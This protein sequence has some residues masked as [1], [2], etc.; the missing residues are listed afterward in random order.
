M[1]VSLERKMSSGLYPPNVVTL[2][3]NHTGT[4]TPA[5]ESPLSSEPASP[6]L[7][8]DD[9]EPEVEKTISKPASAK[10][11]ERKPINVPTKS[12]EV[13]FDEGGA[14]DDEKKMDEGDELMGKSRPRRKTN[15][16]LDPPDPDE[17]GSQPP[18]LSL[19]KTGGPSRPSV[20]QRR[21]KTTGDVDGT[22]SSYR[23]GESYLTLTNRSVLS[24]AVSTRN[25]KS[26]SNSDVEQHLNFAALKRDILSIHQDE[27]PAPGGRS[28][29]NS[30]EKGTATPGQDLRLGSRMD[31]ERAWQTDE[32]MKVQTRQPR[33]SAVT[34]SPGGA[35]V[36]S[37]GRRYFISNSRPSAGSGTSPLKSRSKSTTM[38]SPDGLVESGH[39]QPTLSKYDQVKS[40]MINEFEEVV[41]AEEEGQG[42][43]EKSQ[44]RRD[45][46]DNRDSMVYYRK[47]LQ[48][49]SGET[50]GSPSAS[51]GTAAT[52]DHPD[53]ERLSESTHVTD[54][55]SRAQSEGPDDE[56]RYLKEGDSPPRD[57]KGDFS[58]PISPLHPHGSLAVQDAVPDADS[59]SEDVADALDALSQ[60]SFQETLT[61]TLSD[62]VGLA[63]SG[64]ALV[65]DYVFRENPK[66][67]ET[68]SR[69][70]ISGRPASE[71]NMRSVEN[72]SALRF[73]STSTDWEGYAS[74]KNAT[75]A[76]LNNHTSDD[77]KIGIGR[78]SDRGESNKREP[79]YRQMTPNKDMQTSEK[80][81]GWLQEELKRRSTIKKEI[82]DSILAR[83]KVEA[84][85]DEI[86]EAPLAKQDVAEG[87][88]P[89]EQ[90]AEEL[91]RALNALPTQVD[92]SMDTLERGDGSQSTE[93][94][95]VA[96]ITEK[97]SAS[98]SHGQKN[99]L[100]AS[101]HRLDLHSRAGDEGADM[102]IPLPRRLDF[103]WSE[104]LKQ[105][106]LYSGQKLGS[107]GVSMHTRNSRSTRG[108]DD[109]IQVGNSGHSSGSHGR[110]IDGRLSAVPATDVSAGIRTRRTRSSLSGEGSAVEGAS[111]VDES[112]DVGLKEEMMRFANDTRAALR[113]SA[114]PMPK[115]ADAPLLSSPFRSIAIASSISSAAP[116]EMHSIEVD[117]SFKEP[118][119]RY[120]FEA[121]TDD[122]SLSIK[123]SAS[124]V[125]EILSSEE[126]GSEGDLSDIHS[127][128]PALVKSMDSV[129]GIAKGDITLS[130]LNENTGRI[131]T[132]KKA[133]WAN[134]VHGAIW[135][136]RRMRRT[137]GGFPSHKTQGSPG[138]RGRSSLPVEVDKARVAG[139]F[140]SVS[141]TQDAALTHLAHDE[142]DEALEL[143]EDII[144]A[145]YHYFERALKARE[146]RPGRIPAKDA[147]DFQAYIGVALHNLGILN[148]LN[149]EYKQAFSFF[150]RAIE[151]KKACL[152]EGHPDHVV[153]NF[154][155]G[156]KWKG[157]GKR[158]AEPSL[159]PTFPL[160]F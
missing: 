126:A 26:G 158:L 86:N 14:P 140:K 96:A 48:I 137:M 42:H 58:T 147:D 53:D 112:L 68:L 125:L 38:I 148:L 145:Y 36:G 115:D 102:G 15:L 73:T 120:P 82:N 66:P 11:P 3:P 61:S 41:A 138:M 117:A 71:M 10:V 109:R 7:D 9:E 2:S 39:S 93:D 99:A 45:V 34:P 52:N 28:L 20:I 54:N 50:S 88:G 49:S 135:R 89:N 107:A 44:Y 146:K 63:A 24:K 150:S 131:D 143:F 123:S 153:S 47:Y 67:L 57:V 130:L 132:S 84:D 72:T 59:V 114:V 98:S 74:K 12:T 95:E 92:D 154:Y 118:R 124:R 65:T 119:T 104:P 90:F 60:L 17:D 30:P 78:G 127:T 155:W 69:P 159:I 83:N 77:G 16:R 116:D 108:S 149:G 134:R 40:Q 46:N 157:L 100:R 76:E 62:A 87:G 94:E 51:E 144:F 32:A 106:S 122:P 75:T 23:R 25:V 5:P 1:F 80:S 18:S 129:Y 111:R 151:N 35:L 121:A 43:G 33:T 8:Y 152:G 139:G 133:T 22:R 103:G 29:G 101:E 37:G 13:P 160:F 70:V 56:V 21:S 4:H 113:N 156:E 91:T 136:C 55:R 110:S 105:P 64:A 142:I 31:K 79:S 19:K 81:A 27:R 128:V 85:E 97:S 6:R 141:S